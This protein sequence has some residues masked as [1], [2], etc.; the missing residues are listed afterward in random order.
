MTDFTPLEQA[1]IAAI[2]AEAVPHHKG[3]QQQITE[4]RVL[5]RKNTGGGFFTE[6]DVSVTLDTLGQKTEPLAKNVYIGVDGL[7]YGLGMILHLKD[8]KASLLEGYSVGGED[9]SAIDFAHVRYA[10]ISTPG[11]LPTNVR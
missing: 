1:A 10:V 5:S 3:I 6:L 11:P 7:E 2:V 9:T 4:S 8:G